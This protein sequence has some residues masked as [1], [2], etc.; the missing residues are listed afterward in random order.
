[1][2]DLRKEM[3]A[4]PYTVFQNM[5][6]TV[7]KPINEIYSLQDGKVVI[8]ESAGKSFTNSERLFPSDFMMDKLYIWRRNNK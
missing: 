3:G 6:L 4:N 8:N 5:E 2:L 7:L 1:M